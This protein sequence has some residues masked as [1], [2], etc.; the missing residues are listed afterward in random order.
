MQNSKWTD[1]FYNRAGGAGRLHEGDPPKEFFKSNARIWTNLFFESL[2]FLMAAFVAYD[3]VSSMSS[4]TPSLFSYTHLQL[5][6]ATWISLAFLFVVYTRLK[7]ARMNGPVVVISQRGVQLR[8]WS[9]EIISWDDIFSIDNIGLLN[10]FLI[11][12]GTLIVFV[13]MDT[14][15][16]SLL[17]LVKKPSSWILSM[18]FRR[19]PICFCDCVKDP[20]WGFTPSCI[21]KL[22]W[23][24]EV[25]GPLR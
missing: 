5:I 4:G 25:L 12:S 13:R 17:S 20:H 8:Q 9:S 3:A 23:R 19:V 11:Y 15:E 18:F 7:V 22:S 14:S 21:V 10:P 16:I 24:V 6:V 2:F 1:L